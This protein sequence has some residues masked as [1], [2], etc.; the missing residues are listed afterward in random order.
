MSTWRADPSGLICADV[1]AD[2]TSVYS[3]SGCHVFFCSFLNGCS[4]GTAFSTALV[5]AMEVARR[6]CARVRSLPGAWQ[7]PS[8]GVCGGPCLPLCACGQRHG[9]SRCSCMSPVLNVVLQQGTFMQKIATGKT[10]LTIAGDAIGLA[11][12]DF[13][14]HATRVVSCFRS[15][16]IRLLRRSAL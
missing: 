12:F 14:A 1:S 8:H 10:A 4:L 7:R 5:E 3:L 2:E 16:A 9:V 15:G 6:Q 11:C 13:S